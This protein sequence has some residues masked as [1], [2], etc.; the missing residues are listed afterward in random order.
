MN[1]VLRAHGLSFIIFVE[2]H[3]PAHVHVRGD[4]RMKIDIREDGV[5]LVW[6]S[7]M[8]HGDIRKALDIAMEHRDLFL[9]KWR[10]IHG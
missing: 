1:V 7:R 10:E 2:D 9:A 3:E 8:K 6:A 4:G 5:S